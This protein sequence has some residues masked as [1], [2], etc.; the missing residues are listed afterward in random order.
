MRER[1]HG[2]SCIHGSFIS[3]SSSAMRSRRVAAFVAACILTIGAANG[4]YRRTACGTWTAA[5]AECQALGGD[6]VV[7]QSS[8]KNAE[9]LAFKQSFADWGTGCA[10]GTAWIGAYNCNANDGCQWTDGSAT[11]IS[12]LV[13]DQSLWGDGGTLNGGPGICEITVTSTTPAPAPT[14]TPAPTQSLL[15]RS[16][17]W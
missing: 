12:E 5:R 17:A 7:V 8:A 14:S 13:H 9:V 6:L 16:R 2:F 1:I 3:S 11:T 10:S 15:G 4:E